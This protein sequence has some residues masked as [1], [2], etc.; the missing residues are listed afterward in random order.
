MDTGQAGKGH[1]VFAGGNCRKP[2]ESL[3]LVVVLVLV[4]GNGAVEDEDEK[5]DED[6]WV[7]AGP[8]CVVSQICNLRCV[9]N[10][11]GPGQQQR[12]ADSKSAIRRVGNLR[13]STP[14]ASPPV[15]R[16][17]AEH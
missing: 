4:I 8:R 7:A 15:S 10:S 5:E 16:R 17:Q 11:T 13:Y 9:G 6:D 2:H 14:R 1:R 12:L 3:V